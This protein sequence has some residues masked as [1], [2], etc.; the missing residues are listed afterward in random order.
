M[1]SSGPIGVKLLLNKRYRKAP[2][3]RSE[4]VDSL[5]GGKADVLV[6]SEGHLL[7]DGEWEFVRFGQG[8][9]RAKQLQ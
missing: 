7:F 1:A 9:N 5:I 3:V 2:A 6:I 4:H 8:N